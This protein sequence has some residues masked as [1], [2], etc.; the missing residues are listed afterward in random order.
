MNR[1]RIL[2]SLFII[3]ILNL[4]FLSWPVVASG[5]GVVEDRQAKFKE[6]KKGMRVLR[7]SIKNRDKNEAL[8]AVDFHIAWS[9]KLPTMFPRGSEASVSNGSD[10]SSDIWEDF[11]RFERLNLDYQNAALMIRSELDHGDYDAAMRTF[12][13]MAR[14]CKVCHENFRN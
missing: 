12:F 13:K 8:H 7:H 11:E 1:S 4:T 14:S 6:S 5:L 3:F 2:K 9:Q 10:A